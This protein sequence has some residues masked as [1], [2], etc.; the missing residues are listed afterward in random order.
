MSA[1]DVPLETI[2]DLVGHAGTRVTEAV[3]RKQLK[4]VISKGAQ[5]MNAVFGTGKTRK[6]KSA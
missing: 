4:P 2:A 6:R 3:Y 1:N 5:T